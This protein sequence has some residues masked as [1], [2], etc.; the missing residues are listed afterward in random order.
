MP[1]TAAGALP[2]GS[3][4]RRS[5]KPAKPTAKKMLERMKRRATL[6]KN[7]AKAAGM[8]AA[9]AATIQAAATAAGFARGYLGANRFQAMGIDMALLAGLGVTGYGLV[10]T[11][12][13]KKYANTLGNVGNGLLAAGMVGLGQQ[14]GEQ[15]RSGGFESL[16]GGLFGG[17]PA[18]RQLPPRRAVVTPQGHPAMAGMHPGLAPRR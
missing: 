4:N 12:Q 13:G 7:K 11:Y 2:G 9:D 10:S 1:R 6:D 3:T 8:A 18:Q 14:W 16:F 17:Q 5:S 15:L